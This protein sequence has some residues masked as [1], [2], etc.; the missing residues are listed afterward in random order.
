VREGECPTGLIGRTASGNI[1][2]G[3]RMPDA[4]RMTLIDRLVD[5][6]R[7]RALVVADE[8]EFV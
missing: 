4:A 1:D 3:I 5:R 6:A 2:L 8:A 7:L